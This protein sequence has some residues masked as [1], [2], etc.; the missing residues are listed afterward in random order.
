MEGDLNKA[1][2]LSN[3]ALDL[4]LKSNDQDAIAFAAYQHAENYAYEKGDFMMALKI[5]ENVYQNFDETVTLKNLGSVFKT[6]GF[7]HSQ[8]GNDTLG[9][10]FYER[11]LE[12]LENMRNTPDDHHRLGRVSALYGDMGLTNTLNVK[13]EIGNSLLRMGR[14][15]DA[16]GL[17]KEYLITANENTLPDYVAAGHENLG[18]IYQKQGK[19]E[20]A[21][22]NLNAAIRQWERDNGSKRDVAR[23]RMNLGDIFLVIE[24]YEQA[25]EQF[26]FAIDFTFSQKDT[27]NYLAAIQRRFDLLLKTNNID[28]AIEEIKAAQ[29]IAIDFGAKIRIN[30]IDRYLANAYAADGKYEIANSYLEKALNYFEQVGNKI[31]QAISLRDLS[32]NNLKLKNYVMA[33][34]LAN[35]SKSLAILNNQNSLVSN[36]DFLIHNIYSQLGDY[37]K[38]LA[39]YV[40]YHKNESDILSANAQKL[41]KE[42]QVRQNVNEYKSEKEAATLRAELLQSQNMMYIG[43]AISLLSLLIL[44]SY[45]YNQMRNSRKIISKRNEVLAD[46]MATKDKFFSIIAHDIRS[47]LIALGSVG[48]QMDYYVEKSNTHKMKLLSQKVGRTANHL[49]ALLDNLLNWA[50]LQRGVFPHKPESISIRDLVDENVKMFSL[51]SELKNIKII[52]KITESIIVT[53]DNAGLNTIIRNL[54]SNAL[55]FTPRDGEIEIN[56]EAKKHH[57][58]LNIRDNGIGM[59]ES[60]MEKLFQLKPSRDMGTEGEKGTGLGLMLCK[61]LVELNNG[62]IRVESVI[63][64]GSKFILQ[65]PNAA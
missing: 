12:T 22:E 55:K 26:D 1:I 37:E 20:L 9:L 62:E 38:A 13:E 8:L 11:S 19:Y 5:L 59:E 27:S 4:A 50:L 15:I 2:D 58:I 36:L 25:K 6:F 18:L 40:S 51:N 56:C 54:L 33:L 41:L 44:G 46:L 17:F 61:E 39:S 42:E 14:M 23:L 28:L 10:T 63:N 64:E 53:A 35:Q 49:S 24:D 3:E 16:E 43:L 48:E 65:L 7:V 47:P 29:N 34:D 60:K 52:N 31:N 21:I 57:V 30:E 45:L 32:R